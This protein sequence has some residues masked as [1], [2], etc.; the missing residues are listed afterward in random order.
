MK[1]YTV[2]G[3]TDEVGPTQVDINAKD[4]REAE[5]IAKDEFDFYLVVNISENPE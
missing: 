2:S 5:R 4:K 1:N 3:Y